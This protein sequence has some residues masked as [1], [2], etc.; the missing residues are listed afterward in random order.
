M[1][2]SLLVAV[3]LTGCPVP[4]EN[5][6]WWLCWIEHPAGDETNDDGQ[7]GETVVVLGPPKL[8]WT[9]VQ[10]A[11]GMFSIGVI[12]RGQAAAA[13]QPTGTINLDRIEPHTAAC[14]WRLDR[15]CFVIIEAVVGEE[16][17]R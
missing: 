4:M 11:F 8:I 1:E 14:L 16:W 13:I 15:R 3:P 6:C 10:E 12:H 7:G 17:A 5:G 9:E 2:S